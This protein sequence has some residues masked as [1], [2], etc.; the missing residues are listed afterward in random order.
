[1]AMINIGSMGMFMFDS[2]V[3]VAVGVF[4]IV[5]NFMTVMI[6]MMMF[7]AAVIQIIST[8]FLR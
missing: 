3:D 4:A 1:M 2:L 7:I 6:V 5:K 8:N